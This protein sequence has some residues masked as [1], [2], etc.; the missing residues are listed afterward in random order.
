MIDGL[1]PID[2]T[3]HPHFQPS[4]ARISAKLEC[5]ACGALQHDNGVHL[6]RGEQTCEKSRCRQK[7]IVLA[8][9][10]DATGESLRGIFGDAG[11]AAIVR[12]VLPSY[13]DAEDDDLLWP[14]PLTGH[15]CPAFIAIITSPRQLHLHR[16]APVEQL[17]RSLAILP[18]SA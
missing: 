2:M 12:L 9:P 15:A 4:V 17:V 10:V 16:H 6:G 3:P 13:R 8:L 7:F 18:R 5:P 1:H 11:A 14:L